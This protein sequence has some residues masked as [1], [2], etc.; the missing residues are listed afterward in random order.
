MRIVYS[1]L[2]LLSDWVRAWEREREQAGE[3]TSKQIRA[4]ADT[5][6][7]WMN[8]GVWKGESRNRPNQ[9]LNKYHIRMSAWTIHSFSLTLARCAFSF[10]KHPSNFNLFLSS[11]D[12]KCENHTYTA[13]LGCIFALFCW[14]DCFFRLS[15][16]ADAEWIF[17]F[18]C[19]G[20]HFSRN[21]HEE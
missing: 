16:A 11:T 6:S 8:E 4:H 3:Q 20:A 13:A 21:E 7:V 12:T 2:S 1:Q 5:R 10:E 9:R 15:V 17:F 14:C 19:T 18:S